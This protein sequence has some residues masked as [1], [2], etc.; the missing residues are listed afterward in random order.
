MHRLYRDL[1]VL[2]ERHEAL[3]SGAMNLAPA[4]GSLLRFDRSFAGETLTVLVNFAD[5]PAPWPSDLAGSVVL[6]STSGRRTVDA[7]LGPDEAV[8]LQRS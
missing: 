6:V 7:T 1:L 4:D 8:V 2:R 3:R 5:E